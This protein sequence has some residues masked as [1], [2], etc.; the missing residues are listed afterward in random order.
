[1]NF[2]SEQEYNEQMQGQAEQEQDEKEEYD[3]YLDK[4]LKDGNFDLYAI[5]VV[6][7]LINVKYPKAYEEVHNFL[8][9][10]KAKLIIKI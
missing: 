8:S 3:M 5:E 9:L 10:E 4:L 1:M 6:Q 7:D 2:E